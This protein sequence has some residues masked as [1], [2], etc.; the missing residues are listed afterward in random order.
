MLIWFLQFFFFPGYEVV[1]SLSLAASFIAE[2]LLCLWLLIKGV[3]DEK[4]VSV[5]AS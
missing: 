5:A 2:G 3:K 4:P 1:S